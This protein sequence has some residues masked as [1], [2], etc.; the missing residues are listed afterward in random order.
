M[1]VG[2]RKRKEEERVCRSVDEQLRRGLECGRKQ[3]RRHRTGGVCARASGANVE[4]KRISSACPPR[5]I[6]G[7]SNRWL[8]DAVKKVTKG[9]KHSVVQWEEKPE[10][11]DGVKRC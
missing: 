10:W 8:K 2:D 6:G 7:T 5:S 11:V 4:T 1:A 9:T 3:L